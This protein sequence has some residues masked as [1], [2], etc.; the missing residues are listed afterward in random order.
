MVV[1]LY[2]QQLTYAGG[3][4]HNANLGDPMRQSE[5]QPFDFNVHQAIQR[6]AQAEQIRMRLA[7]IDGDIAHDEQ[8]MWTSAWA[9]A[10]HVMDV[11]SLQNLGQLLHRRDCCFWIDLLRVDLVRAIMATCCTGCPQLKALQGEKYRIAG[12]RLLLAALNGKPEVLESEVQRFEGVPPAGQRDVGHELWEFGE[13]VRDW[14]FKRYSP[15]TPWILRTELSKAATAARLPGFQRSRIT[16]LCQSRTLRVEAET[17]LNDQSMLCRFR[18]QD[19]E[20]HLELLR[21]VVS[22]LKSEKNLVRRFSGLSSLFA[23]L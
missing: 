18:H 3:L 19:V 21:A 7:Q 17:P 2:P 10:A 23:H 13:R 22:F 14:H 6:E 20:V 1:L 5:N 11:E 16:E 8:E 15:L 9:L 4:L 12:L